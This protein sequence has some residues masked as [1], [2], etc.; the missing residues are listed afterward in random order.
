MQK[1]RGEAGLEDARSDREQLQGQ[2]T[3]EQG[4]H[5]RTCSSG[6]RDALRPRHAADGDESLDVLDESVLLARVRL[7]RGVLS[8]CLVVV[9]VVPTLRYTPRQV[10]CELLQPLPSAGSNGRGRGRRWR[11]E[12]EAESERGLGIVVQ[13]DRAALWSLYAC[14]ATYRCVFRL[15]AA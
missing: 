5:G 6:R 14:T 15:H 2:P 1:Q 7:V 9:P 10:P 8:R 12:R 4:L 3:M 11:R 13:A